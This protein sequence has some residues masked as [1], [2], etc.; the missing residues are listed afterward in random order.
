[1]ACT[2]DRVN[3]KTHQ[4]KSLVPRSD[5]VHILGELDTVRAVRHLIVDALDAVQAGQRAKHDDIKHL[6][7][8]LQVFERLIINH[9]IKSLLRF[10]AA[11]LEHCD[12]QLAEF[13]KVNDPR[14]ILVVFVHKTLNFGQAIA[15][16]KRL[17]SSL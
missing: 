2:S 11:L 3:H 16:S 13:F 12:H 5:V 4:K 1:M 6:C 9:I 10:L 15:E 7:A 14:L 17:E 8:H